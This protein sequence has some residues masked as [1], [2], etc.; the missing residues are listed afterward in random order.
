MRGIVV[1]IAL[2][3]VLDVL[4]PLGHVLQVELLHV[5]VVA[6][7]GPL[8]RVGSV[9]YDAGD[10]SAGF[11][12]AELELGGPR[13]RGVGVRVVV[14][15]GV[16]VGVGAVARGGARGGAGAERR[17]V[18]TGGE[19]GGDG[20]VTL[21]RG[22]GYL[23]VGIHVHLARLARL[24][25]A[26]AEDVSARR[27]RGRRRRRRLMDLVSNPRHVRFLSSGMWTRCRKFRPTRHPWTYVLLV[28]KNVRGLNDPRVVG[29]PPSPEL[30]PERVVVSRG[31][32]SVT[33]SHPRR[34]TATR[35]ATR[36]R[37]VASHTGVARL[38]NAAESEPAR[39]ST[40][41]IRRGPATF[42]K[43]RTPLGCS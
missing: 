6:R 38:P 21:A 20:E 16:R 26:V 14:R 5:L 11:L 42:E 4:E 39:P 28:I 29:S 23:R 40:R 7:V 2:D 12:V 19:C 32:R 1:E 31:A 9:A 10:A 8:G 17:I 36:V 41:L 18:G 25:R 27:S 22:E 24:P 13:R 3:A 33:T 30:S 34:T 15:V 35:R 43:G 37:E